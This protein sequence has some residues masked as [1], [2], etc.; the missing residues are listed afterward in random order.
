MQV[1]LDDYFIWQD[2]ERRG[3]KCEGEEKKKK[4]LLPKKVTERPGGCERFTF[5]EELYPMYE[6]PRVRDR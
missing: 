4:H 1:S 6:R 3:K 2:V 5:Y